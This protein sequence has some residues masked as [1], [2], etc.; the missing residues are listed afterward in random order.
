MTA[1]FYPDCRAV[2]PNGRFIL[3]ARSP[4][5]GAINHR[6]GT[7]AMGEEFAFKYRE[8]QRDFRYRLL[9]GSGSVPPA[10]ESAD[11]RRPVV[12]ERRQTRGEDSPHDLVVS[13]EGWSIIRTHGFRPEVIAVSPSGRDV[14]RVRVLDASGKLPPGWGRDETR[15]DD[16]PTHQWSARHLSS[17]SAGMYWTGSSWAYFL[18]WHDNAYFVWRTY[19]G[20]RL[21]IDLRNSLLLEDCTQLPA[22][23]QAMDEEERRGVL[24]LLA[25]LSPHMSQ[26][27]DLIARGFQE[28]GDEKAHLWEQLASL[29]AA[30]HLAGVHRIAATI[31][32]LRRWEPIDCR[33]YTTSSTAL[34]RGWSLEVQRFRPILRHSLRLLGEEPRPFPAYGFVRGD[35]ARLAIPERVGPPH[36]L[37]AEIKHDMPARQVLE[38]LGAP[39]HIRQRSH[40]A[41]QRLFYWTEEWEY[42]SCVDGRWVTWRIT[43]EKKDRKPRMSGIGEVSPY[44]LDTGRRAEELLSHD[45]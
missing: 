45:W 37:A 31:P 6:D 43:W 7:P 2:S 32:H 23:R 44:W 24:H 25:D 14:V 28:D 16:V 38:L 4:H 10:G 5:N 39:D 3:E 11:E 26:I 19:W 17:T 33:S 35:G 15:A 30:L 36:K 18:D 40:P 41:G 1:I 13:D 12:W 20:D 21:V 34:G 29:T 8:H 42:D 9:S 22:L 27:E